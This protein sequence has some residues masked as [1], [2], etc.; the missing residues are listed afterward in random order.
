MG[1]GTSQLP[2]PADSGRL[3]WVIQPTGESDMN[4]TCNDREGHEQRSPVHSCRVHGRRL[5]VRALKLCVATLVAA[6]CGPGESGHGPGTD[7]LAITV[8]TVGTWVR[9]ASAGHPPEWNLVPVASI[10]PDAMSAE[11]TPSDFGSVTS[12]A[13]GPD[14]Q[15][16]YVADRLNCEIGV[17]GL[18]GSHIR[19]L[20]D[21]EKVRESS[22]S[23]SI[24][25][26]GCA[27]SC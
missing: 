3:N 17:F 15:A 5:L 1:P 10:G 27:T 4:E 11:A 6:S 25:L 12:V 2:V 19:T 26:R 8:D 13:F 9:V 24:P 16:V 21:A 23:T 18:D 20:G 14:E 7:S 22:P